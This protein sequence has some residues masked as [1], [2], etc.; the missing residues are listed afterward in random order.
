M[1]KGEINKKDYIF[2]SDKQFNEALNNNKFLEHAKVFG[3]MYGTLKQ[4]VNKFYNKNYFT[5]SSKTKNGREEI[6]EYIEGLNS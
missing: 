2:L 6:L 4:T 1:R 3:Y 5:S